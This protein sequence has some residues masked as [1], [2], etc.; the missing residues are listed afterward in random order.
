MPDGRLRVTLTDAIPMDEVWFKKECSV[1][2][3]VTNRTLE[4]YMHRPRHPIP[5]SKIG[6]HPR[7][8]RKDVEEWL[9]EDDSRRRLLGLVL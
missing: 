5:Y 1:R 7:F 2:L 6:K 4:T 8:S 9:R 3:R